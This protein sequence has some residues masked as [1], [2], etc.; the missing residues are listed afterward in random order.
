MED[1]E[2]VCRCLLLVGY[3]GCLFVCW[4]GVVIKF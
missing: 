3:L 4:G 1:L 2:T